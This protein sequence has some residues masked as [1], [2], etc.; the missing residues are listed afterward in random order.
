MII[1]PERK[2]PETIVNWWSLAENNT[3]KQG[4]KCNAM[5]IQMLPLQRNTKIILL[6]ILKILD[7]FA[8][9][10]FFISQ[11]QNN[12]DCWRKDIYLL[13]SISNAIYFGLN[14]N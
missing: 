9:V 11:H 14:N 2:L 8:Q 6:E 12:L 7:A 10:L 5:L 3:F 4:S 1:G 13:C